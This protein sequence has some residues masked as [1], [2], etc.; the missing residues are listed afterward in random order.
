MK[1]DG[2][3]NAVKPARLSL[4]H[5][6]GG[7]LVLVGGAIAAIAISPRPLVAG[8]SAL[9]IMASFFARAPLEKRA[10]KRHSAAWDRI[11]LFGFSI[12]ILSSGSLALFENGARAIPALAVVPAIIGGS[13]VV[14]SRRGHR[15]QSFEL[16]GMA[17]L[18]ASA[19][20]MMLAGGTSLGVA[21]ACGVVLGVHAA[22]AVPLVRS[23]LRPAE[24][25]RAGAAERS[26]LWMIG[27]GAALLLVLGVSRAAVA[28]AP[29]LIQR[30][31]RP[32]G[33]RKPLRPA[34]VGL[35][36]TV[37]LAVAVALLVFEVTSRR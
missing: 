5:E 35:R 11:A 23:E 4:P 18:G 6:H 10:L 33:S 22:V 1:R 20:P 7:Y 13:Y 15:S 27:G 14:R 37:V 19:G 12:V 28:L 25:G 9:A 21:A 8:V 17:A 3:V 26:A 16:I 31:A 29:R 24:R 30:F 36:E 34:W 2:L 32:F